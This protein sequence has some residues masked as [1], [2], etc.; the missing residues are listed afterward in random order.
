MVFLTGFFSKHHIPSRK[1]VLR[2]CGL[3]EL[4]NNTFPKGVKVAQFAFKFTFAP[5][6]IS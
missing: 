4:N 3:P 2:G 6:K 5:L 1:I